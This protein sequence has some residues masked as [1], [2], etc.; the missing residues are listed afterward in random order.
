MPALRLYFFRSLLSIW[1]ALAAVDQPD[2]HMPLYRYIGRIAEFT[3]WSIGLSVFIA[4]RCLHVT[5][6]PEQNKLL[7]CG[8]DKNTK[9][10]LIY[11]S[12][13]NSLTLDRYLEAEW[14]C[15]L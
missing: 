14:V 15:F 8:V 5:H 1:I 4:S 9:N 3:F 13:R 11:W 6:L 12:L 10:T 7:M 2:E